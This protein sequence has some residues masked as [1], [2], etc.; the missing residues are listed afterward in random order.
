MKIFAFV[1]LHGDL[2]A[3]EKIKKTLKEQKPDVVLCAGD[4]SIFGDNF[5]YLVNE[6]DELKIPFLL[7]HG[8]HEEESM[9]AKAE[10]MLDNV[11]NLHGRVFQKD[12]FLFM[13]WGGGGFSHVDREFEQAAKK[14]RKE[15]AERQI[16]KTVIVTHAPP[17][18]TK[19]DKIHG[20]Y[21]GSK[22]I[23]SFIE[24]QKP[25]LAVCGH[26][27]ENEGKED[28]IGKTRIINPGFLGKVVSI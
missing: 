22:S 10:K 2:K 27:H 12:D 23:R 16:K 9:V 1:D 3:L 26:L 15:I 11:V 19:L 4:I 21:A 8:N 17:Y 24:Q 25:V 5:F 7:V 6:I 18:K 20:G 14:F 28:T 13:G